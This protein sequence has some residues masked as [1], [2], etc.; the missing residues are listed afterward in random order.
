MRRSL[1]S[2]LLLA[3]A[4]RPGSPGDISAHERAAIAD[5]LRTLIA[6]AYD[7]S[8]PN[9]VQR[10]V[11]LYPDRGRVISA[12][13]GRAT[14]SRDTVAAELEHF[15]QFIGQNMRQPRWVWDSTW[16]DVLSP[17]AAVLT[18]MYHIPHLTPQGAPHSIGGAWPAVFVRRNGRWVI[19]QEHLSDLPR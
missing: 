9:V 2:L 8:K 15:W 12:A 17:N 6:R 16:V 18:G 10:M 11:S 13:A 1:C 14:S 3:A 19:I 5:S 7:L 4:C